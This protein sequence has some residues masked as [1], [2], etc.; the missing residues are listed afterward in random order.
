M[1]IKIVQLWT[2]MSIAHSSSTVSVNSCN[3]MLSFASLSKLKLPLLK[4]NSLSIGKFDNLKS[5]HLC[6]PTWE[7]VFISK[8]EVTGAIWSLRRT[9][10][11]KFS[12]S[13]VWLEMKQLSLAVEHPKNTLELWIELLIAFWSS[14]NSW[15]LIEMWNQA[16]KFKKSIHKKNCS[17]II[18]DLQILING[19]WIF[20]QIFNG[21]I[22]VN[23]WHRIFVQIGS[24][25]DPLYRIGLKM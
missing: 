20:V 17:P 25:S 3:V 15:H 9:G 11:F 14:F 21:W 13:S 16:I 6:S 19:I 4:N 24:G 12:S 23:S 7:I 1:E 18:R 10:E 5:I 22:G 2:Y 8:C